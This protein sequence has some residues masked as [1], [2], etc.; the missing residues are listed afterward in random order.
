MIRSFAAAVLVLSVGACLNPVNVGSMGSTGTAGSTGGGTTGGSV[1]GGSCVPVSPSPIDFG[2]V[3]IGQVQSLGVTVTNCSPRAETIVFSQPV[4]PQASEFPQ[5]IVLSALNLSSCASGVVAIFFSPSAFGSASADLPV[6]L[7]TGCTPVNIALS[8]TSQTGL[9][10]TPDPIAFGAVTG[11]ASIAVTCTNET[12]TTITVSSIGTFNGGGVFSLSSVPSL[13]LTLAQGAAF[14]ATVTF[15]STG[16]SDLT[17]QLLVVFTETGDP[18]NLP[19]TVVDPI[20]EGSSTGGGTTNSSSGGGTT[21]STSGGGN[22]GGSG[23]INV[24]LTSIGV[25]PAALAALTALGLTP[26]STSGYSVLLQAESL[27]LGVPSFTTL[28]V[29]PLT[30]ANSAGPITFSNVDISG[31][32]ASL[33]LQ[34]SIVP[35]AGSTPS[36]F[37]SCSQLASGDFGFVDSFVS[38]PNEVYFGTPTTD[39][40]TGFAY[41]VPASY[42]ALLDCSAGLVPGSSGDLLDEG[43]SLL[44]A[45][46]NAAAQGGPLSGVIFDYSAGSF[47]YYPDGYASDSATAI[48]PTSANGI[49]TVTGAPSLATVTAS[50]PDGTFGSRDLVTTPGSAYLVYYAPGT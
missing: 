9:F 6:S 41:A 17:D 12:G 42:V 8:G 37:P 23:T 14:G 25:H 31:G 33:G 4:G 3:P 44:Y 22:S 32:V 35:T 18:S 28:G 29:I 11:D 40:T 13:P 48:S 45:S 21:G 26:P 38:A 7:C 39:V 20:S 15:A 49:A 36:S 30:S 16:A 50:G 46:A 27:D 24:T 5:S 10:C 1:C 2:Q 43:F 47:L 19:E 34:S